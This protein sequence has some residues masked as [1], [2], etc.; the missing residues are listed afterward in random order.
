V[1]RTDTPS[2]DEREHEHAHEHGDDHYG[3]QTQAYR[4]SPKSF[5]SRIEHIL[6]ENP[7]LPI[8]ITH[9][10]KNSEVGGNYI[11]YTIRTGVSFDCSCLS[12][13]TYYLN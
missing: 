12:V 10:G 1:T 13:G 11:V 6:Y 2:I 9:A 7:D 4:R 8:L 5:T 3:G